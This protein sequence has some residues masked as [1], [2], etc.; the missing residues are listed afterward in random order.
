MRHAEIGLCDGLLSEQQHVYIRRAWGLLAGFTALAAE[1]GLDPLA[2]AEQFDRRDA[3]LQL[4]HAIQIVRLLLL[5]LHRHCLVHL[6]RT[7]DPRARTPTEGGDHRLQVG[8]AVSQVAAEAQE[9]AR[10][11][12]EARSTAFATASA[13]RLA[14]TSCTRK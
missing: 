6:R 12:R 7:C 2:V 13:S 11:R 1:R 5:D 9:C 14:R 3:T 8:Q 10:H 4:D